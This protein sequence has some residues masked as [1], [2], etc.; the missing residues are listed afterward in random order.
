MKRQC[1]NCYYYQACKGG[2]LCDDYYPVDEEAEDEMIDEQI[3]S[4]RILYRQEWQSYMSEFD[5]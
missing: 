4:D 5:D 1:N 2:G 3:E